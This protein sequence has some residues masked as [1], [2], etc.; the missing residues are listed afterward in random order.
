MKIG[1]KIATVLV[2]VLTM[3]AADSHAE[4]IG[5]MNWA[6]EV[7]TWTGSVQ[8]YGGTVMDASTTWWLTGVP[9]AASQDTI[10][11]WRSSGSCEFTLYFET[12]LEDLIGEDLNVVAFAGG[13]NLATISASADGNNYVTIGTIGK[14]IPEVL[15]EF[16]FDFD[17]LVDDVH[18]VKFVRGAMGSGTGF[19]VDAVG[20]KVAVPEPST[21]AM[22]VLGTVALMYRRLRK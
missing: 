15:E 16:W 3:A 11:G 5:D 19:F 2:V 4:I 21:L 22:L 9:D 1:L 7:S 12:G 20:G 13:K 18:Y 8:N 14:G 17:G 6:D 10:A